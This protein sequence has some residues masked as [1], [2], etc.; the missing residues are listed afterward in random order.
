MSDSRITHLRVAE[1]FA[2]YSGKGQWISKNINFEVAAGEI[3]AIMGPSGAGKSTLIKAFL[4]LVPDRKGTILVNGEDV[5]KTGLRC[6]SS[7]V[8]LVPQDDILVDELSVRE[9]I[10]YFHTIVIDSHQSGADV[11]KKISL[12]LERLGIS[13]VADSRVGLFGGAKNI[14]GGQRKRANIAMELIND[15]DILII[16]E[17]TSGLSSQDSL[18]LARNLRETADSGKIVIIVIHQPSSDIFQLF[19]RLLVL[20][21]KGQCIRS[22]KAAEVLTWFDEKAHCDVCRSTF[23]DKLLGA[24]ERRDDWSAAVE[25]FAGEFKET[26]PPAASAVPHDRLLRSPVESVRDMWALIKRQFLIKKRDRMSQIVTWAAPPLLGFLLASVF[27]AAPEGRSYAFETNALYPQALFMLI[28]GSMFLGMVSSV[29]EVIKDRGILGREILR[30]LSPTAYYVSE[31]TTLALIGAVQSALLVAVASWSLGAMDFYW[32]NFGVIYLTMLISM[33]LGLLLST[34]FDSP[35]TAYNLIPLVLIPQII[36]GGALLPYKDMGKEVYLWE[37][38]DVTRRPILAKV[39]PASWAY[40]MAMR[41]NYDRMCRNSS[42]A[43]AAVMKLEVLERGSFLSPQ[44]DHV[45]DQQ[46]RNPLV[47]SGVQFH[48]MVGSQQYG[49]YN[50]KS[51]ASL[52]PTGQMTARSMVW[53]KG[54]ATWAPASQ[55]PELAGLFGSPLRMFPPPQPTPTEV[56]H[57]PAESEL[58]KAHIDDGVVLIL[59]LLGLTGSGMVWIRRDYTTS[60]ARLWF[61]QGALLIALPVAYS[62]LTRTAESPAPPGKIVEY[63][64]GERPMVWSDADSYCRARKGVL[65]NIEDTVFIFNHTKNENAL[66]PGAYWTRETDSANGVA[67]VWVAALTKPQDGAGKKVLRPDEMRQA[68]DLARTKRLQQKLLSLCVLPSSR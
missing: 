2:R 35:I 8:G 40:Q 43:N 59:I 68:G 16:D 25:K 22:G 29:F 23:P 36:L 53:R 47:Q 52:V 4:G 63:I 66:L 61:M 62:Y 37:K 11:D 14:S 55:V 38:R 34:L 20:D 30:G 5:T 15:P 65:A 49:P 9:N 58:V 60:R 48:L 51:L 10:R 6:V 45:L 17:P 57:S 33:A 3:L 24:V 64:V 18:D 21:G 50:V 44:A 26:P 19:D 54:M 27:K 39:M 7:R 13:K 67:S 1:L 46:I 12:H 42:S 41:L 56:P 28:I 31:I 32:S